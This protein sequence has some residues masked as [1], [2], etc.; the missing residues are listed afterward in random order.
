MAK[1][2]PKPK[3]DGAGKSTKG[4]K[5]AGPVGFAKIQKYNKMRLP[6]GTHKRKGMGGNLEV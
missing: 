2:A 4:R 3:K 5:D 6:D 1:E